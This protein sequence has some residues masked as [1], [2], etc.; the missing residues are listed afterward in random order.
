MSRRSEDSLEHPPI[1]TKQILV[2]FSAGILANCLGTFIG[3]PLDTVK[4][5]MQLSSSNISVL[6]VLKSTMRNEGISGL[7]KGVISPLIG[8]APIAASAF[9]SNELANRVLERYQMSNNKKTFISGWFAGSVT[10]I[11]TTP[12]EYMK[13]QKQLYRGGD[14]S[15]TKIVK[16]KG[17]AGI[18]TGLGATVTRDIPGW[19]SYFFAYDFL[20]GRFENYFLTKYDQKKSSFLSQFIAGGLAGQISWICWYPQDVIKSY[21]QYHPDSKWFASTAKL[22]YHKHGLKYFFKGINP[23][24]A[25]AFPVNSFVFVSYEYFLNLLNFATSLS[26]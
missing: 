25:R 2:D 1:F 10:S 6:T 19:W 22:L 24:L 8:Q 23:C 12:I 14:L 11:F 5:R 20:K 21:I 15:Y 18:F 7:F 4:V 16:S 26:E 13:I 3:H 17:V 9:M